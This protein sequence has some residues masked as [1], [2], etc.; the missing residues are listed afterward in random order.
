MEQLPQGETYFHADPS[1]DMKEAAILALGA[2]C[3][4]DGCYGQIREHLDTLV[5]FL[6]QELDSESE[7]IRS[8]A[9]WTLSKFVKW[10]AETQSNESF[11]SYL[12]AIIQ[13]LGDANAL[14]QQSACSSLSTTF[15]SADPEKIAP[16]TITLL[17]AFTGIIDHY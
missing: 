5:P 10:T 15:Q 11:G 16:H 8:T 14:T 12:S 6:V 7:L 3:D 17:Q 9:L 13:K 2:T 4:Q 1:L